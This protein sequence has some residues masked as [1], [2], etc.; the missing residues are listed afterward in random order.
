MSQT[1]AEMLQEPLASV[2]HRERHA[3]EEKLAAHNGRVVLFGSGTLGRRALDLLTGLG[4]HVLAF[5][6]NNS[7]AWGTTIEGVP[8]LSPEEAS[9]LYGKEAVFFVTI[10]NDHHWYSQTLAR[11]TTLGCT[12]ISTYA[13]IFW[14]FPDTFLTLLLLNEPPH[15]LYGE[16]ADVLK[17]ETIWADEESLD[18]YRANIAW[19]ALGDASKLPGP[20]ATW[21][22]FPRDLF[23]LGHGD[24]LVDC[25]AFDG[26][27][28]RT[29]L[30]D[31]CDDFAAI[32]AIEADTV[33]FEN[34]KSYIA[35]LPPA[36][37]AK[38][39]PVECAIGEER[40]VLRFECSGSLTST[41]SEDGTLVDCIPLDEL[42]AG[43]SVTM[44]KMDIEGA[45]HG[46]LLG[47][48]ETIRRDR[49]I[50]AVCVYHTQNDI[51][52]LPLLLSSIM[53]DYRFFLRAYEGDGFQTV[54]YAVPPERVCA[55]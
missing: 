46:A 41:A 44:I 39:K 31:G 29:L 12:S 52:R 5:T 11:L 36:I 23:R 54:C 2:K 22:Y 15:R 40:C 55:A 47:G 19:R 32:Y 48:R 24:V 42:F 16:A 53:P 26:D 50:M 45:E 18:I 49:P 9:R 38:I 34:L 10:W 28:I 51:W 35:S 21:T 3:L 4:A 14:R 37:G 17:A 1:L 27:S 30:A 8:V 7:A 25:G 33:S 20:P 6:D 43:K 13:P